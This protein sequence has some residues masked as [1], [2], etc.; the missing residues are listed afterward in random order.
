EQVADRPYSVYFSAAYISDP[1]ERIRL[2]KDIK[3]P[4]FVPFDAAAVKGQ[5][6]VSEHDKLFAHAKSKRFHKRLLA[7]LALVPM[8]PRQLMRGLVKKTKELE[9]GEKK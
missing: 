4:S 8:V 9:S 5:T 3:G 6:V 1:D 7:K 2:L